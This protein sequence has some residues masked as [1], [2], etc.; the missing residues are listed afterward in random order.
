[1]KEEKDKD[2]LKNGA[3]PAS[4]EGGPETGT[5]SEDLGGKDDDKDDDK[6]KDDKEEKP[7]VGGGGVGLPMGK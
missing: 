4:I 6:D 1:M 2:E 5:G 7:T 3:A